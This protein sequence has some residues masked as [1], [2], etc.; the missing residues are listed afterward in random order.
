MAPG[1]DVETT[2]SAFADVASTS[3]L[4]LA[5]AGR[6]AECLEP[7]VQ[8]AAVGLEQARGGRHVATSAG[9]CGGEQRALEIIDELA[10]RALAEK[11]LGRGRAGGALAAAGA[12]A[13]TL[14]VRRVDHEL[15]LFGPQQ[16]EPLDEVAHLAHVAAPRGRAQQRL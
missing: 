5:V 14:E 12:Q 8:V 15:A 10:V 11:A 13:D 4:A 2:S 7:A 6:D 3:R 9:E 1:S 16:R